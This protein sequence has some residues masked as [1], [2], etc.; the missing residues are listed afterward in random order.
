MHV[1][2]GATAVVLPASTRTIRHSDGEVRQG[3][4]VEVRV[5]PGAGG[6]HLR[7]KRACGGAELQ[8][9]HQHAERCCL[10]SSH[11]P[12]LDGPRR[13]RP[14]SST[15]RRVMAAPRP[16][17]P[18]PVA[19]QRARPRVGG[20]WSAARLFAAVAV[21]C[22]MLL[23]TQLTQTLRAAA[24]AVQ[25]VAQRQEGRRISRS[26]SLPPPALC[27]SPSTSLTR[28]H[29]SRGTSVRLQTVDSY[30]VEIL[31]RAAAACSGR[32]CRPRGCERGTR[33]AV[34]RVGARR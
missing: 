6:Y 33:A 1:Q 29:W 24:A 8:G 11:H 10:C 25:T 13:L 3:W 14:V 34:M 27:R 22:V 15:P 21:A 31:L 9:E 4:G 26:S 5:H 20:V 17:C 18:A 23:G 32:L 19:V 28:S 2:K 16:A 12:G 30:D 7:A